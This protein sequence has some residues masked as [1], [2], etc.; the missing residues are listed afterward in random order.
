MTSLR[1]GLKIAIPALLI[2]MAMNAYMSVKHLREMQKVDALTIES[3]M[4]QAS[5]SGV[6]K[7]LTE[8]ETGQRG[9]LLT[10]DQSYLEPY[11]AAKDRIGA[12]FAALRTQLATRPE[13]ERSSESQ[14]ESIAQSKQGEM[15][16]TIG[17]RQRGYRHR[18]FMMVATDEGKRYMDD[19]RRIVPS[20]SSAESSNLVKLDELKTVALKNVLSVTIMANAGLLIVTACLFALISY[21]GRLLTEKA[22]QSKQELAV[23]DLQLGKLTSALSGQARLK[24]SALNTNSRLLLENYGGFLPKQGHEYAEQMKEAAIEMERLRQDLVGDQ[25]MQTEAV[26]A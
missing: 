3:S 9:Y 24:L 4:V 8:M 15:E 13:S 5:I 6:L 21:H 26:A 14:L 22:A 7:D 11:N 19:V 12:D 16:R 17:L 1:T 23:R 18:S 2:G 25:T 20:L 10:G